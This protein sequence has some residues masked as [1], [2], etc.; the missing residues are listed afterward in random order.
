MELCG[1]REN[2][3]LHVLLCGRNGFL[4]IL[5]TQ[6]SAWCGSGG[7]AVEL[8]PGEGKNQASL[9]QMW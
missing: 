5:A 4:C 1:I 8:G 7:S 2:F 9:L 6:L 3:L